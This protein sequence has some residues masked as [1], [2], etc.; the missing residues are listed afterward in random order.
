M[1][2]LIPAFKDMQKLHHEL[3]GRV[4][5]FAKCGF[6]IAPFQFGGE[7]IWVANVH[8]H[9]YDPPQRMGQ[10][11][12][13]LKEIEEIRSVY[14]DV[15]FI[16]LGDFNAVLP[17]MP[18]GP[19]ISGD[20]DPTSYNEDST[21]QMFFEAGFKV[22]HHEDHPNY[23][24][25]PTRHKDDICNHIPNRTLDFILCSET[26]WEINSYSILKNVAHSDHYPVLGEFVLV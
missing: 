11:L 2:N 18:C 3:P 9:P 8:L 20:P 21:F 24:T 16:I 25:Y 6:T 13:I 26:G 14:G 12:Y 10:V 22:A 17:G 1:S 4:Y 5:G 19:F 15:P 7:R 23:Y